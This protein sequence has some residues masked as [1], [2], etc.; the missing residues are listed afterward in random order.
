MRPKRVYVQTMGCQMNEHD[1]ER[2]LARL[3][4]LDYVPTDRPEDA[5]LIFLNTCTVR[6]RSE[7]KVYSI[8]GTYAAL[9]QRKPD[10]VVA[11][12]GCV[13]QQQGRALLARVPHVDLVVGTDAIDRFPGLLAQ[14]APQGGRR[15][16][17]ADTRFSPTYP[18]E[19]DTQ[20]YID[21]LVPNPGQG[22]GRVKA[23]VTIMR[24]CDH[25]C[26]FCIVPY[27]RGR[28]RSRPAWDIVREVEGL[29]ARGIKE[30]TLLG[31]NVNAYG[32]K[33]GCGETFVGLLE[34]LD[35]IPG[36]ERLRFTTSHPV[37]LS[38]ELIAAFG[39]LRT[40]CEHLH[41]P[42]QSGSPRILAAMRREYTLERYLDVVGRL[43]ARCPELALTTDVIVGFPGETEADFEAT[44]ALLEQVGYA[45]LYAFKYSPRPRTPAA[46]LPDQVPEPVK[47]ARLARVLAVQRRL[48]DAFRARYVGREVEVL[49]E[50]TARKGGGGDLTGRTRTNLI[51]N[52]P[53][54]PALI[55][56]L[57]RVRVTAALPHSLRGELPA[58]PAVGPQPVAA[59]A[60]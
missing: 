12:G 21:H 37:D 48:A 41:L 53:G 59:A 33:R 19:P 55:G 30:V 56:R 50:G 2:V 23:F 1:T 11:V 58:G 42:V 9:K 26:T 10:L 29:V 52:F 44:L 15:P 46:R 60:A 27:V 13:A 31:Q 45:D 14:L 5:D 20:A 49:V 4:S 32:K 18:P 22:V 35:R 6:E 34:Q 43:R 51:V 16:R 7:Q 25:F 28:E 38:D 3:K 54:D 8:L 39:R 47:E 24:G 17:L 40:L 57:V 36:L